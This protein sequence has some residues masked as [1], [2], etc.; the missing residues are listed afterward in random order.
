MSWIDVAVIAIALGC[1]AI[2][3]VL[4]GMAVRRYQRMR[5]Q[6][7]IE[8]SQ[9][10]SVHSW[11]IPLVLGII[12][13][14]GGAV[15]AGAGLIPLLVW[16]FDGDS[17]AR[18]ATIVMFAVFPFFAGLGWLTALP[19]FRR[20]V[21][22]DEGI[23]AVRFGRKRHIAFAQITRVRRPSTSLTGAIVVESAK[24]TLR[25]SGQVNDFDQLLDTL[26]VPENSQPIG[27]PVSHSAAEP[28][29]EFRVSPTRTRVVL[30]FLG[31]LFVFFVGWPWFLVEGDNPVR[32]SFA[33]V[34]IGSF[35]WAIIALLV[36]QESF[37]RGQPNH[38]RLLDDAIEYRRFRTGWVERPASELITATV[39]TDIIYVRG[40]PGYRYPLILTF[41]DGT[42]LKIDDMRAKHLGTTTH[43][44]G[45]TIRA[46]YHNPS[47][48]RPADV[49]LA[50]QHLDRFEQAEN[51]D[52]LGGQI[53]SLGRAIAVAPSEELLA[54]HRELGDLH[55]RTA[56]HAAAVSAY[57]A[58]LDRA[59]D[60]HLA[61]EGLVASL[62]ALGRKDLAGE[63]A[64]A[65]ERILLA[66]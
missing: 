66:D 6:K 15:L 18:R 30:G 42:R 62:L 32:D 24:E 59:P 35:L 58:R 53:D 2:P 46:K 49:T 3:I 1:L 41:T 11:G 23:T 48:V 51:T 4:T 63:A 34:G 65:A 61:Y 40:I 55:R 27:Q 52:D 44:L 9:H 36:A 13:F 25:I 54:R 21:V 7:E 26:N 45:A 16:I 12:M 56:D 17:D 50:E 8:L 43:H 19:S 29:S 22:D 33:F 60:D 5:E 10:G 31:C 37:Q 64:A 39:E 47:K 28:R 14:G 20:F 57:R 38:L